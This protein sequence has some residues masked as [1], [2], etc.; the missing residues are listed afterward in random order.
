MENEFDTTNNVDSDLNFWQDI[1]DDV[2]LE[3]QDGLT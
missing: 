2:L 1:P 3:L